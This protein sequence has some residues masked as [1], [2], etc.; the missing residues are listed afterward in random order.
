MYL[1]VNEVERAHE[2]FQEAININPKHSNSLLA[3]GAIL[4]TKNE[5]DAALN[6]Y[7]NIPNIQDESFEVWC[8]IGMCFYRKNKLI[9][10][11]APSKCT[12]NN[13]KN[14]KVN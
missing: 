9:A 14:L 12:W 8:N 3:M 6:V 5:I 7:K 13:A 1:K 2:K 11:S 4:Q 10:V